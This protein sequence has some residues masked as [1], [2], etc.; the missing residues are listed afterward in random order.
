MASNDGDFSANVARYKAIADEKLA[1][2]RKCAQYQSFFTQD[3]IE[4][5]AKIEGSAFAGRPMKR[6][7]VS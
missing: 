4:A 1:R 2:L 3:A 7:K 6:N 5:F